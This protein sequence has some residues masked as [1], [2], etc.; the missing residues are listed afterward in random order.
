MRRSFD[1]DPYILEVQL[2][3]LEDRLHA[4]T[5]AIATC[6]SDSEDMLTHYKPV[7]ESAPAE[8]P[9]TRAHSYDLARDCETTG[10]ETQV[11]DEDFGDDGTYVS[12]TSHGSTLVSD[13]PNHLS[14]V[15]VTVDHCAQIIKPT[16]ASSSSAFSGDVEVIDSAP[17]TASLQSSHPPAFAS[18]DERNHWWE[19]QHGPASDDDHLWKRLDGEDN[20]VEVVS[21]DADQP[22]PLF[23]AVDTLNP[24]PAKTP[25]ETSLKASPHYLEVVEKLRNVFRLK[26]FR[27]NQLAAIISTLD[28]RDAVVLMPT[29]GGKS[30]CYQLPA[31]CR[32]GRTSGVTFVIS[33]LRALMSDQVERLRAL[34]IGVMKLAST[35][36]QDG[37]TTQ[38]LQTAST[39]LSLVYVTPEKLYCS[40]NMKAILKNLHAR[41]QLARFVIDEAHLINTWGRDFRS[42]GYGALNNIRK[43]YPEVPIMALTATATSEALQDIVSALGLTDYVFLSQSF[44]RPNLRYKAILK[45]KDLETGIVQFIKEKYPNETGIIYCNARVK[46]EE[47]AK[48]LSEQGLMARHFHAGMNDGDRKHIQQLWQVDSCKIIVATIAF[49]MGV[50]K[51]NVRFV[52]HYDVPNSLDAYC[53]E[54]GRAGRDGK[55][56]DCILYYNYADVQRRISQ[57]NKDPEIDDFQKDR[58]RQALHTVYQFCVNET[59]CRRTLMLNHFTEKFDPASCEGTCDNC[60]STDEVTNV[61]LTTHAI[62]YVKMFKD[63]ENKHMKITG[64]QSTNA[65]RGTQ[66]QEMARR[67]FDTLDNF[68]K[69]SNIP[70]DLVKRLLD[71]LTFNEILTTDVEEQPDPRPPISYVYLGP[72]AQ[73][74]L[75]K[76]S[77]VLKIRS[78]RRGIGATRSKKGLQP[79]VLPP[80]VSTRRK[81]TRLDAV[82]DPA[83]LFSPGTNEAN[84][85]FDDIEVEPEPQEPHTG[86]LPLVQASRLGA[87]PSIQVVE[88]PTEDA[89]DPQ[90]EC[91]K[92][93]CALRDEFARVLKCDPEAVLESEIL[94]TVSL[95]LPCDQV[96]FKEELAK[97]Y[98]DDLKVDRKWNAFGRPCL[99]ITSKYGMRIGAANMHEMHK[100]FDYHGAS[101]NKSLEGQ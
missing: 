63:L 95:A 7:A 20:R 13:I 98:E 87:T 64:P 99:N 10:H 61:D 71:H 58:K 55:I 18:A 90:V 47:V 29:G 72:K 49:G 14:G 70:V 19:E 91:F 23:R 30:L 12:T 35:D 16:L 52:I 65:F 6:G 43:E 84:F 78:A 38:E 28:G 26:T 34:D 68:A 81:P 2:D 21:P 31:V 39:K 57:I 82:N 33:P 66:K 15:G 27:K 50:D 41:R 8:P 97:E 96:T 83:E 73:E 53:Q 79:P 5:H 54:T 89:S 77:C 40:D 69:G 100:R 62:Q 24:R 46:T 11:I 22:A 32:G 85:D 94:Q 44:N 37:N 67:S 92:E 9:V 42:S 74:F 45:K 88:H 75:N 36:S 80:N 86:T 4:I 48:R 56:A 25:S 60:T 17:T 76:P 101:G 3:L 51:A 1:S 59:D 93:L